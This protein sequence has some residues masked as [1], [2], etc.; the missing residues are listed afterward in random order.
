MLTSRPC[1]NGSGRVGYAF[2]V[3]VCVIAILVSSTVCCHYDLNKSILKVRTDCCGIHGPT[4]TMCVSDIKSVEIFNHCGLRDLSK[5]YHVVVLGENCSSVVFRFTSE[6]Q[7]Q[8]FYRE[9]EEL[10][11]SNRLDSLHGE[12]WLIDIPAVV[13][14]V[15]GLIVLILNRRRV[16]F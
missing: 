7:A 14:S 5:E 2:A 4:Q 12:C 11:H 6:R 10:L 15:I 9:L 13:V 8:D 16:R 1:P 3:V